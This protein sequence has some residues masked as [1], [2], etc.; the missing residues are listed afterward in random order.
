MTTRKRRRTG[1]RRSQA[2]ILAQAGI[3]FE[4]P[5]TNET[6]TGADTQVRAL[7]MHTNLGARMLLW[8]IVACHRFP[9]IGLPARGL[10]R[11]VTRCGRGEDAAHP[12]Y[13]YDGEEEASHWGATVP[14][15]HPDAGRDP[16]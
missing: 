12:P 14:G 16:G 2:V 1:V 10:V 13:Y 7:R 3:Q 11:H 4:L 15:R 9:G 6:L 8:R 5:T